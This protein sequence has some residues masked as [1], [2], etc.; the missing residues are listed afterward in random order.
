[1]KYMKQFG[2]ILTVT[3]LGEVLKHMILLPIPSSIYGLVLMLAGLKLKIIPLTAV[4]GAGNFLIT[5]MPMLFIPSAVGLLTSWKALSSIFL[6]VIFIT[7]VST[8]MVMAITGRITQFVIR[9]DKR[10]KQ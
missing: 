10:R 1:M 4:K 8:I 3:F 7:V 6:P 5:I 9:L 2:I